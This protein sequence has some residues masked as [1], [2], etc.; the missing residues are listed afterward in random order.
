MTIQFMFTKFQIAT[1]KGWTAIMDNAI[2]TRPDIGQQP[3]RE[4]NLYMY[5]YFV[6]FILFGRYTKYDSNC[7]MFQ[8]F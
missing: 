3:F 8:Q 1:W 6:F 4:A 7:T 2:D 5:M